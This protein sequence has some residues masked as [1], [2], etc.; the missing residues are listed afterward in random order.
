MVRLYEKDSV[1]PEGR[2][3]GRLPVGGEASSVLAEGR[4]RS[5]YLPC[6]EQ[7]EPSPWVHVPPG[8]QG[9]SDSPADLSFSSKGL[10]RMLCSWALSHLLLL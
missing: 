2:G 10:L 4:S 3:Q 7:S 8:R 6:Q 1:G 9:S 5:L